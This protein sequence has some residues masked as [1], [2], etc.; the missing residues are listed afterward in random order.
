MNEDVTAGAKRSC[1]LGMVVMVFVVSAAAAQ[2]P[3]VETCGMTDTNRA[4]C[5]EGVPA[6]QETDGNAT[7]NSRGAPV[8]EQLPQDAAPGNSEVQPELSRRPDMRAAVTVSAREIRL[9]NQT[10]ADVESRVE[11]AIGLRVAEY[12]EVPY[13]RLQ[14]ELENGQIWRQISGDRQ[15]LRVN[16]LRNQT[17]DID[18]SGI[19][20]YKLRLNELQRTIPVER[21]R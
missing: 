5:S 8:P 14:I 11:P 3:V 15:H 13:Q 16:L 10:S 7:G 1:P 17:V 9:R 19:G 6:Q 20:A 21:I 2:D 18:E 12:S 4:V